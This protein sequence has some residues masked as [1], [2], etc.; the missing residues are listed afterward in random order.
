MY[1]TEL[2]KYKI[3][4]KETPSKNRKKVQTGPYEVQ[5]VPHFVLV[6]SELIASI[7]L[8]VY[9]TTLD[10]INIIVDHRP[11]GLVGNLLTC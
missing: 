4:E 7:S 3:V 2:E 5:I 10:S 9:R 6:S 11:S 1:R 8:A